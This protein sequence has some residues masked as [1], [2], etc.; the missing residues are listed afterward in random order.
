M[1]SR[2]VYWIGIRRGGLG[3]PFAFVNG[4]QVSQTISNA[5][6]YA[7][8]VS[9]VYPFPRPCTRPPAPALTPALA[10]PALPRPS[11]PLTPKPPPQPPSPTALRRP[12]RT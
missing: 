8:W 2:D 10:A 7:H 5:N 9:G 11:P 6:P 1:N 12:T 3:A 4:G